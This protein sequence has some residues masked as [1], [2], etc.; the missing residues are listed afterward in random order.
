MRINILLI[1]IDSQPPIHTTHTNTKHT[2][3]KLTHTHTTCTQ[4][5]H[6]HTTHTH[7]HTTPTHYIPILDTVA[8]EAAAKS[9]TSNRHFI[10]FFSFILCPLAKQ[11]VIL[12]SIYKAIS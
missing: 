3:Y 6:I 9:L 11:S 7:T 12:S 1:Y 2:T 4:T 8:G 5:I 10:S